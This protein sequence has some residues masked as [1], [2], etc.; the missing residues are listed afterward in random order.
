MLLNICHPTCG[1]FSRTR[2]T[3]DPSLYP[4]PLLSSC[5]GL[6]ASL[7]FVPCTDMRMNGEMNVSTKVQKSVFKGNG[8]LGLPGS[9][10][11][12]DLP[13]NAGDAVSILSGN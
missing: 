12:K 3:A 5:P 9:P 4:L 11:V 6:D 13:S 7:S 8:L 1:E 2:V 10:V